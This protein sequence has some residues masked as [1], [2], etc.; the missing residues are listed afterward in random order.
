MVCSSVKINELY[1]LIYALFSICVVFSKKKK[2][3]QK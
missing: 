2:R 3:K 1:R